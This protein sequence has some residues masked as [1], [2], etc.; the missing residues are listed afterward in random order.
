MTNINHLAM[1]AGELSSEIKRH[2]RE[3]RKLA[4]ERDAVIREMHQLPGIGVRKLARLAGVTAPVVYK[5]IKKGE[6]EQMHATSVVVDTRDGYTF[7]KD[8]NGQLFNIDTAR[9]FADIRNETEWD[10]Y[11]VFALA[12]MPLRDPNE[13][14]CD[15]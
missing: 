9:R 3:I 1:K 13:Q 7:W 11:Q 4:D 14:R 15:R 6:A 12:K 10:R 8:A 5:A 2:Q